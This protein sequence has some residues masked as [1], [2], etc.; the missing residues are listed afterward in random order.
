LI[1]KVL[2]LIATQKK[3]SKQSLESKQSIDKCKDNKDK[4]DVGCDIVNDSDIVVKFK[5]TK[6][7]RNSNE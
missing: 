1:K 7:P 6:F 3:N 4:F 2:D 5:K